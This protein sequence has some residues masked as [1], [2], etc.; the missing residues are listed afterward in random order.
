MNKEAKE[1]YDGD[2]KEWLEDGGEEL[3]KQ[4]GF[5]TF[6]KS[7]VEIIFSSKRRTQRVPK[8]SLLPRQR[9]KRKQPRSHPRMRYLRTRTVT[10]TLLF[11]SYLFLNRR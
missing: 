11:V 9:R 4:V 5:V 8:L 3:L 1:K 2:Y 7:Y 10:K 6:R